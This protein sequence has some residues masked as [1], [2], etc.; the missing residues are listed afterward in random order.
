M[1]VCTVPTAAARA[2]TMRITSDIA[3]GTKPSN[4]PIKNNMT[5]NNRVNGISNRAEAKF[6][7]NRSRPISNWR[8]CA[9]CAASG[10][11]SVMDKG[12]LSTDASARTDTT[13]SKRAAR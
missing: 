3:I 9:S 5:T 13:P 2:Q 7:A 6:P 8:K 12:R 4:P 11:R 10:E 1:P